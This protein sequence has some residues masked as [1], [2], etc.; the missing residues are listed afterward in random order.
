MLPHLLRQVGKPPFYS[1]G[2]GEYIP[3][4]PHPL[5]YYCSLNDER[6]SKNGGSMTEEKII[7]IKNW[8]NEETIGV[9]EI[10][11]PACKQIGCMVSVERVYQTYPVFFNE[12]GDLDFDSTVLKE[13]GGTDE[14]IDCTSCAASF[15]RGQI[16]EHYTTQIKEMKQNETQ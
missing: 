8:L 3:P 12:D 9:I 4:P 7:K 13:W 10:Q 1:H 6:C 14:G 15:S 11:C 2:E 16:Q 5:D